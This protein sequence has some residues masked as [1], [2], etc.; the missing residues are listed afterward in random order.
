M[1]KALSTTPRFVAVIDLGKTNVKV[2]VHDLDVGEDVFVRTRP[3][4]VV[5]AA[6]YPH[7]EVEDLWAFFLDTLKEAAAGQRIDAIS[8]TT[9]GATFAV[10][11]G[12]ELALPILDYEFHGPDSL[13]SDYAAVRPAFAESFT[14]RLPGGLNAA[15]QLYWQ[16][17]SFPDAFARVTAILPYPQ[18]WAFRFC[19]VAANEATSLGVHTD[20]WA[21]ARRDFSS[22]A[23]AEGWDRLFPPM[24]SAFDR[25]GTLK[26]EIAAS[27]SL[28]AS[29]PVYCGIHD[30][31]ASLL[32]HLLTRKPPFTVL[33]TGT[34]V[35]IFAVGGDA[36]ALD[37]TRDGLCNVDAHGNPVPSS[38]FMGGREFE[39]LTAGHAKR[40]TIDDVRTVID[41]RITL[42]PTF[43]P[44]CGPFPHGDGA[45][46]VDPT[47]L[48][49]GVRTAAVSLYLALV[50]R[51]AMEVAGTAGPIVI[52]G[53]FGRDLLFAEALQRLT[54]REVLIAS[55]TTGTSTGAA[56]LA[57]G[58]NGRPAL[59]P[60]RPVGGS[61][62]LTGL[63]AFAEGWPSA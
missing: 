31:N 45:W 11:A 43:A 19:G 33:S 9:H 59:T 13:G 26:P 40:P 8:F 4:G 21:P 27:T 34:W 41:Q 35:I 48:S 6:P 1:E 57:L 2:V 17:R 14:P 15:A 38:R 54:G 53:P 32:P 25:L 63:D 47:T 52:E 49:D 10:M 46:S 50:A 30:S 28:D 7:F 12:D 60:D 44:G 58:R 20:L 56:M 36:S 39:L 16:A 62:D 3:N 29:T 5:D 24:R 51:A 18:Y 61:Y 23:K 55:G 22:F 37:Q 42:R